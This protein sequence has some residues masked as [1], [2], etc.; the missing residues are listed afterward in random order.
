MFLYRA[1]SAFILRHGK[2]FGHKKK[3][4]APKGQPILCILLFAVYCNAATIWSIALLTMERGQ[5][6]FM[7]M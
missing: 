6:T 1:L 3:W 7:R 4:A 2:F 5:P